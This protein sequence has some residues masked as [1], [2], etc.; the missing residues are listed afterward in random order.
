MKHIIAIVPTTTIKVLCGHDRV[1]P[2]EV[3]STDLYSKGH[4]HWKFE[5]TPEHLGIEPR[6]KK[7]MFKRNMKM[8][9]MAYI[10]F[11][12]KLRNLRWD[13]LV[14]WDKFVLAECYSSWFWG[15]S[16]SYYSWGFIFKENKITY[17]KWGGNLSC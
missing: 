11:S 9:T 12:F 15:W 6:M 8:D 3:N 17:P 5:S 13:V 1:L 14:C 16:F 4:S 2:F 7:I 10:L